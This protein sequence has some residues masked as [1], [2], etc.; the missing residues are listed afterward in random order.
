MKLLSFNGSTSVGDIIQQTT[1]EGIARAYVVS[2]NEETKVLKYVQDRSLYLNPFDQNNKDYA[3]VS[4]DGG[5]IEFESTSSPVTTS[6]GFVGT[7]DTTF[8]GSTEV[9]ANRTVELSVEFTNGL[10]PS[11]INKQSGD[12]VYL[13]NRPLIPRNARQKEDIKI[14]LEF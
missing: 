8:N 6:G 2:F 12:I 4:T 9:V 1:S 14:I 5:R 10:A 3:E 13:D 7:I 11:E